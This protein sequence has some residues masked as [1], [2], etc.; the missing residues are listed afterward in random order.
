MDESKIWRKTKNFL[1][2]KNPL[3]LL[4]LGPNVFETATVDTNILLIENSENKKCLKAITLLDHKQ[5]ESKMN[6]I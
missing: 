2:S 5:I 1:S 6:S 4:D 3:L